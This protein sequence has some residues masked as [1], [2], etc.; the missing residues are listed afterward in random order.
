MSRLEGTLWTPESPAAV[1]VAVVVEPMP[2]RA[3]EGALARKLRAGQL[4][5][6]FPI[7]TPMGEVANSDFVPFVGDPRGC[8]GYVAFPPSFGPWRRQGCGSDF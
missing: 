2:S 1:P 5:G 6:L 3:R 7:P 4:F 8:R